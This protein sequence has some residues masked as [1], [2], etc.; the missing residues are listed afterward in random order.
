MVWYIARKMH[1]QIV[2]CIKYI[3]MYDCSAKMLYTCTR[4]QPIRIQQDYRDVKSTASLVGLV[5]PSYRHF[6]C[7]SALVGPLSYFHHS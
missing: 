4:Q 5:F 3:D 6:P 7:D 2:A 1:L